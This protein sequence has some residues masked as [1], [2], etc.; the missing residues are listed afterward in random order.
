MPVKVK[1]RNMFVA[2]LGGEQSSTRDD[3]LQWCFMT[4]KA[5]D[6][7][8]VRTYCKSSRDTNI[9]FMGTGCDC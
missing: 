4:P 3:S 6:K 8:C 7:Q 5:E 9:N 2:N 1:M